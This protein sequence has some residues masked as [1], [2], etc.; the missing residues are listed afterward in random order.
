[1]DAT[2]AAALRDAAI[3]NSWARRQITLKGRSYRVH[4]LAADQLNTTNPFKLLAQTIP[5]AGRSMGTWTLALI[6]GFG[7]D[8]EPGFYLVADQAN[9]ATGDPGSSEV[10][11]DHTCASVPHS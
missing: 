4:W 7:P 2:V 6:G 10:L 5:G 8:G 3:P 11:Q 9:P 1:V